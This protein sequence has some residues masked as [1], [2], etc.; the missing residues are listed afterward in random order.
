M[1]QFDYRITSGEE[2]LLEVKG[3][4]ISFMSSSPAHTSNPALSMYHELN[5]VE[6]LSQYK[7]FFS[8][9]VNPFVEKGQNELTRMFTILRN[10]ELEGK[11]VTITVKPSE[12]ED[13][14]SEF[15]FITILNN[16]YVELV[17]NIS[18]M[19]KNNQFSFTV[20]MVYKD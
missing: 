13:K 18:R 12:D 20:F 3:V 7:G 8:L 1:T 15:D 9:T 4:N 5:N 2:L 16:S 17:S 6:T 11:K 10:C 19:E 14:A